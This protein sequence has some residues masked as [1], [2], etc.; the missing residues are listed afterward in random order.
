[1]TST[2][3]VKKIQYPN[4]T[5]ILTLDSSGSL[6]IDTNTLHVDASNN[7]VGIGTTNPSQA[8]HVAG[9]NPASIIESTTSSGAFLQFKNTSSTGTNRLGYAVHDFVVDTN[10]TERMRIDANGH[11]TMPTQPAFNVT[12]SSNSAQFGS[13]AHQP[14]LDNEI[15]DLNADFASN[16]F[17][18]PVTG[19]YFL[20]WMVYAANLD[21]SASYYYN[22][23]S[24][25]NRNYYKYLF[26]SSF[27]SD[28][29]YYVWSVTAFTDMDA[30]DTAKFYL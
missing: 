9:G 18:A 23:I 27:A 30:N 4:G 21:T 1:M 26:T 6:S 25:S 17:T 16:T 12:M 11:M 19:K 5:D 28:V 3:G 7:R 20:S 2:I 22:L 29:A 15:F 10:G 24:T 14:N 13:G 8:L